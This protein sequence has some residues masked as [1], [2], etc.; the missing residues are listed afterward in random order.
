MAAVTVAGVG[1]DALRPRSWRGWRRR[2]TYYSGSGTTGPNLGAA[3]ARGG[4]RLHRR[5]E[6]R[7]F[8]RLRG[9]SV[10]SGHIQDCGGHRCDRPEL[11][12]EFV[13]LR[14]VNHAGGACDLE[15]NAGRD[16]H[17]LRWRRGP[18][19]GAAGWLR[20]GRVDDVGAGAGGNSVT[21]TYSGDA[22]CPPRP[23]ARRRVE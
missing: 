17:I 18:G 2:L 15:C 14:R 4:R 1:A 22:S 6:L 19:H 5:R 12:D 9:G 16:G 11:V 23:P 7:R 10:G 8:G 13:S 21:A 3:A 20:R